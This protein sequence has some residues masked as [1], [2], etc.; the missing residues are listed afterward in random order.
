MIKLLMKKIKILNEA[1]KILLKKEKRNKPFFD[2]KIQTDLNCFW[3]YTVL[4]S[5]LIFK[6][7]TLFNDTLGNKNNK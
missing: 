3:F 7:E 6:N 4:Y 1:E 5:S 2:N